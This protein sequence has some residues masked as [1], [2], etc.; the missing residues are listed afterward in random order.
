MQILLELIRLSF[1]VYKY[2]YSIITFEAKILSY[3]DVHTKLKVVHFS[4][5]CC[6]IAGKDTRASVDDTL[7]SSQ[8]SLNTRVCFSLSLHKLT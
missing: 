8:E 6:L 5:I 1:G 2:Y 4:D 7:G 3:V